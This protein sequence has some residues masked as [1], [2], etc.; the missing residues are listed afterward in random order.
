MKSF[1]TIILSVMNKNLP[2]EIWDMILVER[3]RVFKRRVE[4]F[5]GK[6]EYSVGWKKAV[7]EFMDHGVESFI[8]AENNEGVAFDFAFSYKYGIT[9]YRFVMADEAYGVNRGLWLDGPYGLHNYH[10]FELW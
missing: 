10:P 9:A 6:F 7:L 3:R 1:S 2:P 4:E 5:E 8:L